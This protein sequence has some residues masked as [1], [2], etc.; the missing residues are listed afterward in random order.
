MTSQQDKPLRWRPRFS[1]R[2]LLLLTLVV[3][4][5]VAVFAPPMT[6]RSGVTIHIRFPGAVQIDEKAEIRK[7]SVFIG[8]T[9]RVERQAD[10]TYLV[11]ASLRADFRATQG[12]VY[13]WIPKTDELPGFI[14][15]RSSGTPGDRTRLE[16]GATIEGRVAASPEAEI[17]RQLND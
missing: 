16:D 8:K 15:M 11:T 7:F 6:F 14:A 4:A 17:I 12:D 9:R 13:I 1:V 3:G 10:D 5:F 2:A